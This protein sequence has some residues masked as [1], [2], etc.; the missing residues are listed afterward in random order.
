MRAGDE[1]SAVGFIAGA[2]FLTTDPLQAIGA[3]RVVS[4]VTAARAAS[5]VTTLRC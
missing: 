1:F 3:L 4:E 5:S 2:S